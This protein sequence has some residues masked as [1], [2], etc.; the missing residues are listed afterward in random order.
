MKN[1]HSHYK[2]LYC[3][4]KDFNVRQTA[5]M[6]SR[7]LYC[8]AEGFYCIVDNFIAQQEVLPHSRKVSLAVETGEKFIL[9][10]KQRINPLC[11]VFPWTWTQCLR[12]NQQRQN[13]TLKPILRSARPDFLLRKRN[14]KRTL[15]KQKLASEH[16]LTRVLKGSFIFSRKIICIHYNLGLLH[17][18][19]QNTQRCDEKIISLTNP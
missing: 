10:Q 14:V 18:Q 8:T 3:T 11:N 4:A 9:W 16:A 13:G 17:F 19:S 7:Q 6:H 1:S 15:N 5:L 12:T 2:K